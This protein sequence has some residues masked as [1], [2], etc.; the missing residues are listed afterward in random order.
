MAGV[1]CRAQPKFAKA[2]TKVA[3]HVA[4]QSPEILHWFC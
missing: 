4:I 1:V 2:R 3:N